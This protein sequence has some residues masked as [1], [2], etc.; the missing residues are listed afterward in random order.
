MALS[1]THL[2]GQGLV[3]E[4]GMSRSFSDLGYLARTK[5]ALQGTL[6]EQL[7]ESL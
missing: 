7:K 1:A 2:S 4:T 5:P 3:L 6:V